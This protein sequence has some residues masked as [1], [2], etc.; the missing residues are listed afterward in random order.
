MIHPNGL[1]KRADERLTS[2]DIGV[3]KSLTERRQIRVKEIADIAEV[4]EFA[5]RNKDTEA[6]V[7]MAEKLKA[8]IGIPHT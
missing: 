2:I 6:V 5:A 1:T 8:L 7:L 3:Y 4:M